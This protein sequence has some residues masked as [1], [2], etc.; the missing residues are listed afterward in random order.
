MKTIVFRTW[1]VFLLFSGSTRDRLGCVRGVFGH[2]VR[3]CCHGFDMVLGCE[4]FTPFGDYAIMQ[5]AMPCLNTLY[6]GRVCIK[7]ALCMLFLHEKR[8]VCSKHDIF[9]KKTNLQEAASIGLKQ[10]R[11]NKNN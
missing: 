5:G 8:R 1:V 6:L 4:P 7:Y 9:P 3:M 11:P 2:V 10:L